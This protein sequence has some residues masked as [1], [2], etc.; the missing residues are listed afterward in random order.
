M[1]AADGGQGTAELIDQSRLAGSAAALDEDEAL[2]VLPM[3]IGQPLGRGR[4]T[5]HPAEGAEEL[6]GLG[7]P[8]VQLALREDELTGPG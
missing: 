6:L 4:R 2:G 8:A 3:N 5:Q 7:L 1:V